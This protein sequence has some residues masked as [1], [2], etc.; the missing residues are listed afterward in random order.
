MA[1]T[2]PQGPRG[3][4][5]RAVPNARKT[6]WDGK[7]G[8]AWKL[9]VAAPAQE[10]RANAEILRFIATMMGVPQKS[11]VLLSGQK[12]RDKVI[13]VTG[14]TAQEIESRIS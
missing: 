8:D 7:H 13:A 12:C 14:F 3:I 9:K 5:V 10:D 1:D 4:K 11:A 2:H 6:A